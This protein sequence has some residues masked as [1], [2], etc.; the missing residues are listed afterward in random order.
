MM[1]GFVKALKEQQVFLKKGKSSEIE[2][3][4]YNKIK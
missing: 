3:R 2:R 4:I 1:K